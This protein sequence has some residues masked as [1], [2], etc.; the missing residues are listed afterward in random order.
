MVLRSVFAEVPVRVEYSLT[1]LGWSISE[2]LIALSEWGKG[3]SAEIAL[4]HKASAAPL[5]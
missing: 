5:P 4:A 1:P 3:H 2:P